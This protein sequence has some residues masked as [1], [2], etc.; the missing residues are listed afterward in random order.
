[1]S[2]IDQVADEHNTRSVV[3]KSLFLAFYSRWSYETMSDVAFSDPQFT[4]GL[5]DIFMPNLF[6]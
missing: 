1:M 5:N 2:R 4:T 6:F 3:R